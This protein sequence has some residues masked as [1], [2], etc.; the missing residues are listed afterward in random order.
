M[1]APGADSRQ[2][3]HHADQHQILFVQDRSLLAA[4]RQEKPQ[5]DK[6]EN[7]KRAQGLLPVEG[8]DC[9]L[10]EVLDLELLL[11]GNAVAAPCYDLAF[12]DLVDDRLKMRGVFAGPVLGHFPVQRQ[13]RGHAGRKK[14]VYGPSGV[15]A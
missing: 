13:C 9:A 14:N 6:A 4:G 7:N 1:Q 10:V 5:R 8:Q 2:Q 11:L 3:G 15:V 12:L